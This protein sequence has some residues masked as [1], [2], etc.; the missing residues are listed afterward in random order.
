MPLDINHTRKQ[1]IINATHTHMCCFYKYK[2]FTHVR[3]RT[4]RKAR[5]NKEKL[6]SAR[7][8]H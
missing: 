4:S 6:K 2:A 5:A 7:N 1:C 8:E 3:Y